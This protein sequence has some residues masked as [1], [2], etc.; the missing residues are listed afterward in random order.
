MYNARI[1]DKIIAKISRTVSRLC[2]RVLFEQE[3]LYS[4]LL[5]KVR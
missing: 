5:Q 3:G 2:G 1:Q 4:A